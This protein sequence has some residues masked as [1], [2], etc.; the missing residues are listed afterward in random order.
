M[1]LEHFQLKDLPFR[2]SPDPAFLYLSQIHSRAKAYMESTIWFTDGFV[3]ITGEIGS[4]KTTLI[5]TFLKE[6]EQDVVV[7]QIN[8]TQ[9][10]PTEFLQSVLAQFGYS[11]FRMRKAELLATLNNFLIEQYSNGRKVLLIVDEAQN[12]SNKVLEEVR[13]LSGVETTKEKVLR[14]IL[15]GQPE[16]N[17]KLDSPELVQLKQRV[18][19]RFHL[20]ALSEEDMVRYVRHRLDVAGAGGREIF[21]PDVFAELFRYTG[22]TPR[23]I[24]TLCD[25]ALLAAFS[26]DRTTVS[27]EELRAAIGEL[28]WVEFAAR[29]H[30]QLQATVEDTAPHAQLPV[31]RLV[32]S[33]KGQRISETY[34]TP[35]RRIVIG[36]TSDNDLQVDSKYVS[37]HHCQVITTVDFSIV[38]DL[39]STNGVYL[40]GK[41]LR[42]HKLA[43]GDVLKL[44]LHEIAYHEVEAPAFED[45]RTLHT[46]V[47][48]EED[49]AELASED[50]DE[51]EEEERES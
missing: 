28:Q 27:S 35:G 16:L 13:M 9:V 15:A 34:L 26:Q 14:I 10:S 50:D 51:T 47:L 8:Q 45:E 21:E 1:Y 17:A 11:P 46:T 5:E 42:R 40:Q 32:L 44:G 3:V 19:L 4:G 48:T 33:V 2:L 20:T 29:T 30:T 43:D 37:R 38:E 25:T 6:I 36:R 49:L 12:L 7:A 24:N 22:G 31:G 23:L 18:R 41:R 39:N